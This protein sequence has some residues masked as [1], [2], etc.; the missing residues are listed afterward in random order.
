MACSYLFME[1][2]VSKSVRALFQMAMAEKL[3]K[4]V[5]LEPLHTE[6]AVERALTQAQGLETMSRKQLR[7]MVALLEVR[8]HMLMS[9]LAAANSGVDIAQT[10]GRIRENTGMMAFLRHML[11]VKE[12]SNNA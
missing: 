2:K 9:Q 7:S 6:Q 3:P 11:S 4:E 8:F 1:G 10:Q 12:E 5:E